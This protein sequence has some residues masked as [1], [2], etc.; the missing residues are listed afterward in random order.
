MIECLVGRVSRMNLDS[1]ADATRLFVQSP[2]ARTPEDEALN[3]CVCPTR[4]A[5]LASTRT[6][7]SSKSKQVFLPL[8]L[9]IFSVNGR[10]TS[11]LG[12]SCSPPPFHHLACPALRL[13]LPILLSFG[14]F[15]EGR[16]P[17]AFRAYQGCLR[18]FVA[19]TGS[20]VQRDQ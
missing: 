8:F 20:Y 14:N 18:E 19:R 6:N 2:T 15:K 16:I 4:H 11:H 7:K 13:F 5:Q 10:P 1:D 9:L 3:R 17:L 12:A